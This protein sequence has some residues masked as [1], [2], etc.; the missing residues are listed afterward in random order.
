VSERVAV[1]IIVFCHPDRPAECVCVACAF[2]CKMR[3][4]KFAGTYSSLHQVLPILAQCSTDGRQKPRTPKGGRLQAAA[5]S[6]GQPWTKVRRGSLTARSSPFLAVCVLC[7]PVQYLAAPSTGRLASCFANFHIPCRL[8]PPP[9]S[10]TS[11]S[12]HQHL[13]ED[14][15]LPGNLCSAVSCRRTT[16]RSPKGGAK[17]Q[18]DDVR[19]IAEASFY[20]RPP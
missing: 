16:H 10:S 6:P 18:E 7:N 5:A 11:V 2:E 8:T 20:L 4:G 19:T 3:R 9:P 14:T 1:F 17:R 15:M 12:T 13:P